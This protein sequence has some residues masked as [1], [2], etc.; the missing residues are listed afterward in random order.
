MSG[1]STKVLVLLDFGLCIDMAR[2]P[3][4]TVFKIDEKR[5]V[6]RSFPCTEMLTNQPWTYQVSSLK[7]NVLC[8]IDYS[9]QRLN[10]HHYR[11]FKNRSEVFKG[12]SHVA[13]ISTHNIR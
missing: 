12:I 11:Q 2:F 6:K 4:D 1:R 13:V 8:Y 10:G 3:P 9:F 5:S 7:I